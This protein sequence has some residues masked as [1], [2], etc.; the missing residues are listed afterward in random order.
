MSVVVVG[1]DHLHTA[2][3]LVE[4]VTLSDVE[5]GK[6]L[7]ELRTDSNLA[8][9]AVISTCL[10]T[11]V[12]AVVDRFHDGV[13]SMCAALAERAGMSA[14]RFEEEATILFDRGVTTHL[15]SVASG[16]FSSVPG[17]SEV[18]GQVRRAAERAAEEGADGPLLAGLFRHA[19]DTGR[20]VRA[21]TAIGRG[22]LSFSH[23]ALELVRERTAGS[24]A[25]QHVVLVGAGQLGTSMGQA[26]AGLT[27]AD[28][29]ARLTLVNRSTERAEELSG[30][31]GN[32]VDEVLG[33]DGLAAAL[34]DAD[35]LIVAVEAAEPFV[36]EVLVGDR[37]TKPLLIADLGV[38]RTVAP[39]LRGAS[40]VAVIDVSDLSARVN[41]A[42]V[43]RRGEVA[44][45]EEVI[46]REVERY[47]ASV[48][49]RG[50]AP[51]VTALRDRVEGIRLA[52]LERRRHELDDL[53]PEQLAKVE[54]LTRS[55]INKVLH[56]PTVSLR[57]SGGT[58]RGQRLVEALRSLFDL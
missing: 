42:L 9:V 51:V 14:E 26:L 11:E 20:K 55:L 12:Y 6:F 40:G 17:E 56:E 29:P 49:A 54:D 41:E 47:E 28:R 48:R 16:L 32:L 4:R 13:S 10:R 18:L 19:V 53:S 38:P 57:E 15:F 23:A 30:T 35:L 27:E 45:A 25:G 5:Q 1:V 31:L 33:F 24:L 34:P 22:S 39:S 50:A 21:E 44:A 7:T 43:A 37:T 46:N 3:D 8:E 58:P 52:E 2:F 36:D